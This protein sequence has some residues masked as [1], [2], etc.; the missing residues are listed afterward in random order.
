MVRAIY[1]SWEDEV[2]EEWPVPGGIAR[3]Y[4]PWYS[5]ERVL[6]DNG[7]QTP[8][9]FTYA[10]YPS[11]S[12]RPTYLIECSHTDDGIPYAKTVHVEARSVSRRGVQATDL[13]NLRPL[14]DVIE[15]AWA[16]IAR[17]FQEIGEQTAERIEEV[18]QARTE[19]RRTARGLRAQTRRAISAELLSEVARIYRENRVG[20]MPTKA[21]RE[22]FGVQPSTASKYVRLARDAGEE[23]GD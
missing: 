2:I 21:V 8:R 18:A 17:P 19:L 6:H 1:R 4:W 15:E 23:M 5:G 20:G 13:R 11:D 3:V 12:R 7:T 9:E 14:E 16:R 10:E 22:H